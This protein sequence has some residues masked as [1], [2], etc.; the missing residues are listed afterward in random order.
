MK[1]VNSL[2]QV[3]T[4]ISPYAFAIPTP[5]I[6]GKRVFI[7]GATGFIGNR[8]LRR[9]LANDCQVKCSIRANRSQ[10]RYSAKN[11]DWVRGDLR[12][13]TPWLPKAIDGCDYVFHLAAAT[14][15]ARSA[16]L[17]EINTSTFRTVLEACAAARRPPKLV[18][19]SSLAAA[20]PSSGN[21]LLSETD[22]KNPVSHYGKSKAACEDLAAE[23]AGKIPI[24]IVRPPIVLGPGD[25]N[26]F[27]LFKSIKRW[28]CH[29]VP[30]FQDHLFSVIHVDDLVSALLRVAE[31]GQ[32]L[33]GTDPSKGIYFATS[34]SVLTYAG[35]GQQIG[36]AVGH[37][38]VKLLRVANW[39]L[40]SAGLINELIGRITGKPR[41]LNRDKCRE[42]TAGSWACSAEKLRKE[43]G[44]RVETPLEERLAETA[45]W[46][47]Q[48]GWL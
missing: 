22:E 8:L 39:M 4:S 42:G 16:D 37:P 21:R 6:A 41:L 13:K 23:Y 32:R 28:R 33:G 20:G 17:P 44:F 29:L 30:G 5:S 3:Q 9:L 47:R 46:Y 43:T 40:R 26:G 14:R 25:G 38:N 12:V 19:V 11:L 24:S 1:S 27:E 45:E 48:A 10:V 36:L 7:T 31:S 35:L 34:D 15:S 2:N 18:F